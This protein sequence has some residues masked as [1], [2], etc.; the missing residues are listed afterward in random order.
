MK[1][2]LLKEQSKGN[3]NDELIGGPSHSEGET[4]LIYQAQG[5]PTHLS[6]PWQVIWF[7]GT[8]PSVTFAMLI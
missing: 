8:A 7:P 2:P 5:T 1:N 3:D 6:H 4:P